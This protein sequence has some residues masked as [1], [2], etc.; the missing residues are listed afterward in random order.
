MRAIANFL[1]AAWVLTNPKH[2][3]HLFMYQDVNGRGK[4]TKRVMQNSQMPDRHKLVLP[5]VW[6]VLVSISVG[7]ILVKLSRFPHLCS[8]Y[9]FKTLWT[10]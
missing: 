2:S 7:A 3:A 6:V 1:S 10:F 8:Q 4:I 9:I 5:E